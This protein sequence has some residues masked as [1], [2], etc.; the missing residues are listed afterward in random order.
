MVPD[1]IY[2]LGD[3]GKEPA[4]KVYGRDAVEVQTR[5]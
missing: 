2:D 1:A 5:L 3:F 4:V